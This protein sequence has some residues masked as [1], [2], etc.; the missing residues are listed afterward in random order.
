MLLK[1]LKDTDIVEITP[2]IAQPKKYT[3]DTS[4]KLYLP[5]ILPKNILNWTPTHVQ[6][7]LAGHNLT[8]MSHLLVDFNGRSLLYL[9][10]Y[11]RNC[12]TNQILNLL[13]EDSLRKTRQT[14]SLTEL[15]YFRSLMDEQ[16]QFMELDIPTWLNKS[17]SNIDKKRSFVCC[18]MM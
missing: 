7:W 12:D 6:G 16:K 9:D 14:L 10:D 11:I 4:M 8:Q 18:R 15:S 1:E 2:V 3:T 13:E 5:P 17:K